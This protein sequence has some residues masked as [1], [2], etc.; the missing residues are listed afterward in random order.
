MSVES[1]AAPTSPAAV[2]ERISPASIAR[3]VIATTSGSSVAQKNASVSRSRAQSAA[4][5]HQGGHTAD[6]EEEAEEEEELA[7]RRRAPERLEVELIP[8]S[9]K[10]NGIRKPNPTAVSF[11]SN[12]SSSCPRS[13]RARSSRRRSR[14][15]AGRARAPSKRTRPKT[16][17]VEIRTASWLLASSV[18]SSTGN[19]RQ[20]SR[21]EVSASSRAMRMKAIRITASCSGWVVERTSVISRIGPNSPTAPAPEQVVAEPG[22]QLAA[23]AQDRDQGADRGRRHRRAGVEERDH[24]PGG[25]ER[26]PSP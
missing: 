23:V 14:P 3:V 19:P 10:K 25:R 6:D 9:T 20:A 24:D 12:S 15:A 21:T 22:V 11:D 7:D 2:D 17:T 4:V 8:L 18:R 16:S 1:I 5:E 13:A 26:P